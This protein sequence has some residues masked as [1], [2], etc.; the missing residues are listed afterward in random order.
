ME[1][2]ISAM[3]PD[4]NDLVD[5][6]PEELAGVLIEYLNSLTPETQQQ[7]NR[8]NFILTDAI[9]GY[10]R[11]HHA[12][13]R[14]ALSEAWA[15]LEREC[16]I[17]PTPGGI[18][19]W[20]F[21]TRRGRK[22]TD[23]NAYEAYRRGSTLPR[24]LLDPRVDA[25]SYPSFLRGAYDTAVFEAMREVEVAVRTAAGWGPEKWG[26]TMMGD[27][28]GPSCPLT[29]K[30]TPE[31]EQRAMA[32]LFVGAIGLYKNPSSH[33]SNVITDPIVAAE[34]IMLASH[35]L[36]IVETRDPRKTAPK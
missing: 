34:I 1:K 5:L 25:R 11:E 16:L 9:H 10:P 19:E 3:V 33:R 6:E 4:W 7:L 27:A 29:D 15:W 31:S 2:S 30:T 26:T 32:A 13:I 36:K 23:R 8:H 17:A 28:F 35:L 22:L 14:L 18:G 12:A 20:T 24:A 21:V